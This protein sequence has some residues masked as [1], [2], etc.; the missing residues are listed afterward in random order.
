MSDNVDMA[1]LEAYSR[2]DLTRREVEARSGRT[3]SFG[4]L[5]AMLHES[6]LPLPRLR[7]DPP[8]PG[9]ELVRQLAERAVSCTGNT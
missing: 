7:S 6:R 4:Q 8:S 1:L 3:I 9:I 2:G 5:L